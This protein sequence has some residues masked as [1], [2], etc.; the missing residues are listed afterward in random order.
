MEESKSIK[1]KKIKYECRA[2]N[3]FLLIEAN[4]ASIREKRNRH[5]D[6][7][8]LEKLPIKY[9]YEVK[10]SFLHH[11]GEMRLTVQLLNGESAFLDVSILRYNSLPFVTFYENGSHDAEFFERPYPNG[12]EWIEITLRKAL[13]KQSSFRKHV[14]TAYKGCCALCDIKDI[15]LLRAAHIVD[16]KD[17]GQDTISNGILLC[18]N[19][20]IAFDKGIIKINPDFT[21][22]AS[23]GLGINLTKI[24]LPDNIDDYP[25]SEQLEN[26]LSLLSKKKK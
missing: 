23:E 18:V 9:I 4:E 16:V 14:L 15:G 12:R 20:E 26:K 1:K 24:K 8:I 17:G 22:I 13:R 3:K 2:F 25:S 11:K 5:I 21:V 10:D 6:R 19:H 7:S